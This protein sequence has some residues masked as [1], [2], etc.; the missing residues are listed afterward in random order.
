MSLHTKLIEALETRR[1]LVWEQDGSDFL[2]HFCIEERCYG[3]VAQPETY[4]DL[5]FLRVDFHFKDETEI[6]HARTGFNTD[7]FK[8]IGIVANGIKER[9]PS[10]DGYYFVAKRALDAD[11]YEGRKALYSRVMHRLRVELGLH[12]K[13]EEHPDETIFYLAR[14]KKALDV[15]VGD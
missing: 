5:T 11:G 14:G 7:Q 10:E 9:F 13:T 12:H 8:V 2:T 4:Q 3:I 6:V 1:D 15:L